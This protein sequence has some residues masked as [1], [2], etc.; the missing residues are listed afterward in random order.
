M[1]PWTTAC[2]APL[3]STTSQSLLKFLS[4]EL[5]MLSNHLILCHSRLLLPFIFLQLEAQN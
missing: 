1:T 3:L 2:Q 4:T 5:V